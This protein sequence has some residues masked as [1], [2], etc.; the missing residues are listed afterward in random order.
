MQRASLTFTITASGAVTPAELMAAMSSKGADF[1]IHISYASGT[2]CSTSTA[3]AASG[4]SGGP[5]PPVMSLLPCS[6]L[7]FGCFF[8]RFL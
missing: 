2:N 8:R 5:E 7:V 4:G 1:A 6:V 3:F